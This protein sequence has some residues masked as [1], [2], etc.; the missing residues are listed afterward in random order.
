MDTVVLRPA[1]SADL[2]AIVSLWRESMA[3]HG[4]RDATFTP[5][6]NGDLVFEQFVA[7]RID[8]SEAMVVIAE[9]NGAV[10]AYGICVLRSRPDFFEPAQYG[11][12]T[13]I[14][15]SEKWRRHGIGERVLDAL[16]DWLVGRSVKR[17]EAE[18]VTANELSIGFWR[19]RGFEPYYQAMYRAL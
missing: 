16:C 11:L 14:D 9:A 19:K 7:D 1:K 4:E 6:A 18:A 15:V 2:S 12:I 8:K 5:S 10:V 13:D 17:V 3:L